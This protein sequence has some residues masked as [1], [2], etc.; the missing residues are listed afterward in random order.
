MKKKHDDLTLDYANNPYYLRPGE[1]VE[2][3]KERIDSL[4]EGRVIFGT[5]KKY[6]AQ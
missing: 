1:T 2:E 5:T 6:E 3:Y 4:I